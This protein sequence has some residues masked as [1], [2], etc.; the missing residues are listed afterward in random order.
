MENQIVIDAVERVKV[1][2]NANKKIYGIMAHGL[3]PE[4]LIYATGGFPLRLSLTGDKNAGTKGI[5][6]MTSADMLLC[7]K[8]RGSVRVEK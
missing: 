1:L 8:Y 4:E 7:T 5:D 2:K 6:Y 3:V